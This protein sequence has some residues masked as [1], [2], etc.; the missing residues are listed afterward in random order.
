MYVSGFCK[1]KSNFTTKFFSTEIVYFIRKADRGD[2][3]KI[4]L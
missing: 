2:I 1:S 4:D 3:V